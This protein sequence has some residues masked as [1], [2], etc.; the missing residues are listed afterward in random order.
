MDG[1][2][3]GDDKKV[4]LHIHL[5]GACQLETLITIA[6]ERKMLLPFNSVEEF[7]KLVSLSKPQQSLTDF[8]KPLKTVLDIIGGS[9]KAL[10]MVAYD[11]MKT[12]HE[13]GVLYAEL[14]FNPVVLTHSELAT[15]KVALTCDEVMDAVIC[16]LDKGRKEFGVEFNVIIGILFWAPEQSAEMVELALRYHDKGV[17][18]ID[19]AGGETYPIHQLHIDGF[20][21]AKESGLHITVHAGEAGPA[22]N[23]KRAIEVLGAERIGHGYNIVEDEMIYEAAK[24]CNI[25]FEVCPFSSIYTGCQTLGKPHAIQRFSDDEVN[26]SISS[27]D[28]CLMKKTLIDDYVMAS[29]VLGLD[30]KQIKQSVLN[31]VDAAFLSDDRRTLLKEKVMQKFTEVEKQY[32]INT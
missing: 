11:F 25:H 24:K 26:F 18:G 8:L 12:R 14:R 16:G 30:Y 32:N 13:A 22:E 2:F 20:K 23:I 28:P 5:N 7:S 15:D 3:R 1:C 21:K 31:G 29:D 27:D 6:R 4:E 10:E 17:V 9:C 19:M